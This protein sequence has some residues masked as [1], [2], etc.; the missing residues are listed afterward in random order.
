[1][2][3]DFLS[4]HINTVD[5]NGN[6]YVIDEEYCS[7]FFEPGCMIISEVL[8]NGALTKV[9]TIEHFHIVSNAVIAN[10][11]VLTI[12]GKS[13]LDSF[14]IVQLDTALNEI[15]RKSY[16]QE[17]HIWTFGIWEF[18][19]YL[20]VSTRDY[21]GVEDYFESY[22]YWISKTDLSIVETM[23]GVPFRNVSMVVMKIDPD[24][25]LN[26]F[27]MTADSV[28]ILQF[29][30]SR[31]L[32]GVIQTPSDEFIQNGNFEILSNHRI[33]YGLE[34][35]TFLNC[36][37]VGGGLVWQINLGA[38]FG[39]PALQFIQ[40][41]VE[42]ANGDILVCGTIYQDR[43]AFIARIS[44]SGE[45]LW[46]R[47]YQVENAKES[48]LFEITE[49]IDSNILFVG[50]IKMVEPS[51]TSAHDYYW[52]LL[53]DPDG[54]IDTTC[55]LIIDL[56]NDGYASDVDCNDLDPNINPGQE[57]IPGNF[58]DEDCDGVDGTTYLNEISSIQY[59]LF[60][61]PTAR[62]IN[63]VSTYNIQFAHFSI[64][65]L[66]GMAVLNGVLTTKISLEPLAPGLYFLLIQ[67]D[68]TKILFT[69]KIVKTE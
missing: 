48:F 23:Q 61:N 58:I 32:V 19:D 18:D 12:I 24:T 20:V 67:D 55:V 30:D 39:V 7:S 8:P 56:D 13:Q 31:T 11:N 29:D 9:K 50:S 34:A 14:T 3:E 65:D 21:Q 38:E 44:S 33:V 26:I 28:Y 59:A 35:N 10:S 51:E 43:S 6:H 2:A 41:V 5:F 46:S 49:T 22:L 42:A 66:T 62:D 68:N 36:I 53:T 37:V 69:S 16:Y 25:L 52:M 57:E 17:D 4:L 54:C 45:V 47:T 40:E 1:L 63:V 60:P 27:S 15:S 64:L